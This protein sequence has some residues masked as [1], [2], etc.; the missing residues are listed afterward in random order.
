ME[1]VKAA[2][3]K[4][5]EDVRAVRDGIHGICNHW[6]QASYSTETSKVYARIQRTPAV[7][8]VIQGT[9]IAKLTVSCFVFL[10]FYLSFPLPL[11]FVPVFLVPPLSSAPHCARFIRWR[12]STRVRLFARSH[13]QL[14]MT[15]HWTRWTTTRTTKRSAS[16]WER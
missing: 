12:L 10:S 6:K 8:A 5:E 1:E 14:S 4:R 16:G 15:I 2:G 7:S 13:P 11:C 3:A 9:A